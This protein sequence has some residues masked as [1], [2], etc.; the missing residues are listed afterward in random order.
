MKVSVLIV[1]YNGKHLL[2]ACLG[3]LR[4]QTHVPDQVIVVDNGSVDGSRQWLE[5]YDWPRLETLFLDTNTGFSGGNNAG[6]PLVRG[7]ILALLNT[8]AVADPSWIE[9]ALPHF[10]HPN[11]GM[12]ACKCVRLQA[13]GVI[14]KVGHLAY[15]DG[16]NRGRGTGQPDD[17]RFDRAEPCLWPD[18]SAAFFRCSML[19]EI[20]F[21]EP[22]FFLYG[23]DAE[24]GMRAR[25]AGYDCMYEP[26][27][28]VRHHHSAG[29]G[30]FA[31]A[32]AYFIE[33]NR[34]WLLVKTYPWQMILMSPWYTLLRYS[35]NVLSMLRGQGSAAQYRESQGAGS[36]AKALLKA[37]LHG[38]LGIPKML[39]RRGSYPRKLTNAQM[40]ALLRK[41]RISAREITQ[42]D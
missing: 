41:Y 3:A 14:D 16:L 26:G 6:L 24:L 32:K 12:V 27:S 38:L 9:A 31:P 20:G 39:M 13:Q 23:E 25:W 19:K 17:G 15:A 37:N 35:F 22:S 5:A 18:G 30:R 21:L 8:D 11:C 29:L 10:G 42:A 4:Q 34:I 7:H 36:L 1:N 2:D 33:R 40:I 28:S